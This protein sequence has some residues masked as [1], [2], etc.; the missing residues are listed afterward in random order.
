MLSELSKNW[1]VNTCKLSPQ[2]IYVK[3]HQELPK[4]TCNTVLPTDTWDHFDNYLM[5]IA[6]ANDKEMVGLESTSFQLKTVNKTGLSSNKKDERKRIRKLLKQISENKPS[7]ELCALVNNYRN[8]KIDYAFDEK[9]PESIT[10]KGRNENW[11]KKLPNLLKE[12]DCF[13][14]VGLPPSN[15]GMWFDTNIKK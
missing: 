2:E 5:S 4:V 12:N 11:M 6:K 14:A 9:C 15:D 8:F 10:L 13:V 3:L 7:A 1:T